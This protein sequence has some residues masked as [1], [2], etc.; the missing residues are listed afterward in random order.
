MALLLVPA[1]AVQAGLKLPQGWIPQTLHP[2]RFRMQ[3]A[4]RH[5][6]PLLPVSPEPDHQLALCRLQMHQLLPLHQRQLA[7][8]QGWIVF[9]TGRNPGESGGV[10]PASLRWLDARL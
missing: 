9:A 1:L 6:R 10:V 8:R 2:H 3:L 4:L 7:R 5:W